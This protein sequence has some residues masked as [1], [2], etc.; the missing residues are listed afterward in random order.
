MILIIEKTAT[1]YLLTDVLHLYCISRMSR[2]QIS[3]LVYF[4]SFQPTGLILVITRQHPAYLWAD[5][6]P[7]MLGIRVI[8]MTWRGSDGSKY[9]WGQARNIWLET[10]C[11]IWMLV[12]TA[13][14]DCWTD[15]GDDVCT[16]QFIY[17]LCL[18]W[19]VISH[20]IHLAAVNSQVAVLDTNDL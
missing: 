11:M 18:H 9:K 20:V 12:L 7:C 4:T 17:W 6:G 14:M 16:E 10:R 19:L 13:V 1:C 5:W 3:K 15:C 2:D 8:L